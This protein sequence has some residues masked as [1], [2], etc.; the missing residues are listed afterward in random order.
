MT[1]KELLRLVGYAGVWGSAIPVLLGAIRVT[2]RPSEERAVW[3]WLT[4]GM[5]IN[6]YMMVV[7]LAQGTNNDLNELGRSVFAVAGLFA[8]GELVASPKVRSW[9]LSGIGLY[10]MLWFWRLVEADFANA[11]S[12]YSGPAQNLV[13]TLAAAGLL[14]DLSQTSRLTHLRSFGVMVAMGMLVTH[15]PAAAVAALSHL[16]YES[17]TR[18][19]ELL[20]LVRGFLLLVGLAFFSLAFL[21]TVPHRSSSGSSSSVP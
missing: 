2:H 8:V 12:P 10:L 4:L 21:W 5:V 6:V 16:F 20:W 11:F 9:I 14:W 17:Q 19:I 1:F 13:L 18:L 7:G 3:M 15:G